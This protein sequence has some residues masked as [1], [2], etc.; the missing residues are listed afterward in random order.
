L[1]ARKVGGI[2]QTA[3]LV[4]VDPESASYCAAAPTHPSLL[5][6]SRAEKQHMASNSYIKP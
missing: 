2:L 6:V 1:G 5:S 3:I 4:V